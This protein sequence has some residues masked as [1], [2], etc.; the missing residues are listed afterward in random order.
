MHLHHGDN[1]IT[2]QAIRS[3]EDDV[4]GF[5]PSSFKGAIT[6]LSYCSLTFLCQFQLFSLEKEL[7]R[8]RQW[9]LNF[10]IVA[11]MVL[12]YTLYNIVAFSGYLNFGGQTPEDI[13]IGYP[14]T[15][16]L[17][18]ALRIALFI[19][20]LFSY[21]ILFHPTRLALNRLVSYCYELY[22]NRGS[23]NN[24]NC[25][26]TDET[27]EL[28]ISSSLRSRL[29]KYRKD[30]TVERKELKPNWLVWTCETWVMF[31]VSFLAA[32]FIPNVSVG[33]AGI[34]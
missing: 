1:P 15:D 30:N 31:A 20:L 13:M 33:R 5:F 3:D 4:I 16:G 8:P 34:N 17:V 23:S 19:T 10:I 2:F 29:L 21:P 26:Q 22:S 28:L 9:K 7:N 14:S 6:C 24:L 18:T 25:D 32:A 27:T 11:S 12:A